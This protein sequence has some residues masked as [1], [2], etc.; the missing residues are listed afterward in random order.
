MTFPLV[1]VLPDGLAEHGGFAHADAL[2]NVWILWHNTE[3]LLH[4]PTELFETNC[5]HPRRN[6]LAY[7]HHMLGLAPVSVPLLAV[8]RK[9]VLT[10]NVLL[11]TS[12]VLCGYAVF[13]LVRSMTGCWWGGV[14]AGIAFAFSSFRMGRMQH[15]Q[16]LAAD[17]WWAL[18]M[19]GCHY[20]TIRRDWRWGVLA[21][22]SLLMAMGANSYYAL[23]GSVLLPLFVLVRFWLGPRVRRRAVVACLVGTA[24]LLGCVVLLQTPYLRLRREMGLE[25]ASEHVAEGSA[26]LTDYLAPAP[27]NKLYARHLYRRSSWDGGLFP[28]FLAVIFGA[29]AIGRVRRAERGWVRAFSVCLLAAFLL[30]LGPAIRWQGLA[31]MPGPHRMLAAVVPPYRAARV[32]AEYG[33]F[34]QFFLSVLAGIGL[35]AWLRRWADPVR[36]WLAVAIAA[37]AVAECACVPI[38]FAVVPTRDNAGPAYKWLAQQPRA[39]IAEIPCGTDQLDGYHMYLSTAHGHRMV[40]GY[41]GFEPPE[42]AALRVLLNAFPSAGSVEALRWL[43]VRYVVLRSGV[44]ARPMGMLPPGVREAAR[45][46]DDVVLELPSAEYRATGASSCDPLDRSRVAEI[47]ASE[48]AAEAGLAHDADLDTVWGTRGSQRAGMWIEIAL[49][50]SVTLCGIRLHGGR[51]PG[52]FPRQCRVDGLVD[53]SWATLASGHDWVGVLRSCFERP[54]DPVYT[55]RFAPTRV[56]R[57][58]ITQTARQF[59]YRWSIAEL[60]LLQPERPAPAEP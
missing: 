47:R 60:E 20:F 9:P 23:F 17:P 4:S 19:L 1:S 11:L 37:G 29:L 3:A 28:G 15:L 22:V 6:T 10:H 30:S 24:A 16:Y 41:G 2:Q 42:R 25:R 5:F 34:V 26:D 18:G 56:S 35:A 7:F 59:P 43:G 51:K 46:P 32:P 27:G 50:R 54:A 8:L 57:L 48:N 44:S 49:R 13:L 40:N 38:P 45:F 58:R 33:M 55:I 21:L 31:L 39:V 52:D 12:F 14:F 53:G 36:R